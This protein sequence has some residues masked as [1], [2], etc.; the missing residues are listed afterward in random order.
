MKDTGENGQ[1]GSKL[2]VG[3]KRSRWRTERME[4]VGNMDNGAKGGTYST[5]LTVPG[6]KRGRR[7]RL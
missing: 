3:G 5:Q 2:D 7:E 4:S 6:V 1:R